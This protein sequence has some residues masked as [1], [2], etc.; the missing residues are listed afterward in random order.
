MLT[1]YKNVWLPHL[2]LCYGHDTPRCTDNFLQLSLTPAPV[3]LPALGAV[4]PE[5]EVD[6]QCVTPELLQTWANMWVWGG[7][8]Y[9]TQVT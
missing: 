1:I 4:P 8:V 3:E 5:S 9:V 7:C 6:R 2:R